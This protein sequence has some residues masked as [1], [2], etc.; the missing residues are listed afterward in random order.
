MGAGPGV[1]AG[2]AMPGP[3]CFNFPLGLMMASGMKVAEVGTDRDTGLGWGMSSYSVQC[4][5]RG[6]ADTGAGGLVPGAWCLASRMGSLTI[7][8]LEVAPGPARLARSSQAG[9]GAR[10]GELGPRVE[11]GSVVQSPPTETW[12]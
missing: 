12:L 9:S 2:L 3:V 8:F 7:H 1:R 11:P 4:G 10:R 5:G 6:G